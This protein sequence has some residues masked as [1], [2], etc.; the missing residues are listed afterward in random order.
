MSEKA[1]RLC[2]EGLALM[3]RHLW[4]EAEEKMTEA[5]DADNTSP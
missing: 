5:R 2:N 4:L 1:E 3:S